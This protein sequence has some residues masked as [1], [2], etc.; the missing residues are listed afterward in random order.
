[1]AKHVAKARQTRD[2]K[3]GSNAQSHQDME[4]HCMA[5]AY[6]SYPGKSTEKPERRGGIIASSCFFQRS[7]GGFKLRDSTSDTDKVGGSASVG[8]FR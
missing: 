1:M 3:L 4:G 7:T 8:T 2:K 5:V 6:C